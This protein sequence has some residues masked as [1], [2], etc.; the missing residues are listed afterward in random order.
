MYFLKRSVTLK[1][2]LVFALVAC[3]YAQDEELD[4]LL[5][6]LVS[7]NPPA[8]TKAPAQPESKTDEAPA[9][10]EKKADPQV[11][12]VPAAEEKKPAATVDTTIATTDEKPAEKKA[13]PAPEPAVAETK[14]E[15]KVEAPA[16]A[17]KK[18][19]STA[20]ELDSLLDEK[21]AEKKAEPAPV[22]AVVETKEEPKIEAPAVA[23]KKKEEVTADGILI[24]S[25]LDEKPAEKKAEPAPAPAVAETK[26][27]PKVEAPAVEK[28]EVAPKP[29]LTVNDKDRPVAEEKGKDDNEKKAEPAEDEKKEVA[30]KDG[31][32]APAAQESVAETPAKPENLSEEEVA[33][34]DIAEMERVRREGL[35]QHANITLA[36]AEAKLKEGDYD[37]VIEILTRIA[38]DKQLV[39]RISGGEARV[40]NLL[41][42]AYYRKSRML[43]Q[44]GKY[45][46]AQSAANAALSLKHPAAEQQLKR[47]E[48]ALNE[49][50]VADNKSTTPPR[51]AQEEYKSDRELIRQR[52]NRGEQYLM[53]GELDKAMEEAELV[54]SENPY[55]SD[56]MR[57]RRR[58][59]ERRRY[60]AD[61]HE[62]AATRK[63][64]IATV[65][66]T[67][68]PRRTYAIDSEA[69]RSKRGIGSQVTAVDA[70][71]AVSAEKLIE[72]KLND[73]KLPEVSFR[74]PATVIDAIDFFNQQSREYDDPELEIS[75]RGVNFVLKLN[76]AAQAPAAEPAEADPFAAA[77]T[78]TASASTS[79]AP[80]IPN[81]SARFISLGDALKLVCDVTGMKY[82]VK[83]NIVMVMPLNEPE[84]DFETRTYNV[85]SSMIEKMKPTENSVS[86]SSNGGNAFGGGGE[87]AQTDN[88][89]EKWK[90][91][92]GDM[93]VLW[94]ARSSIAYI[95]SVSKLRVTNT[96]ENLAVFEQVLQDLNVTPRQIEIEARFV[97]VS[98]KDLNS[99]GFEWALNSDINIKG[100]YLSA[101]GGAAGGNGGLGNITP[102]GGAL[103]GSSRRAMQLKA[104]SFANGMRFLSTKD[105]S[106]EYVNADLAAEDSF[107]SFNMRFGDVDLSMIL[108]MLSQRSD[109]D[110]L[111]APKVVTRDS[112][113]AEMKV[114]EEFIYP[115]GYDVTISQQGSSS[116]N[117]SYSSSS[118]GEPLAI[119]QPTGFITRDVG[120]ILKVTP[121]V[122]PDG[123]MINLTLAPEVCEFKQWL[124]YGT[125]YPRSV[126]SGEISPITGEQVYKTEWIE[127]P[128]NQP[129]F[130]T[131]KASAQLS[132]YNGATVVLGGMITEKRQT[133]DDKIP[134]LGDLPWIGFLFRSKAEVSDKRNLLIFVTARLVD[135]AGRAI[136]SGGDSMSGATS[137]GSVTP[138]PAPVQQKQ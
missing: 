105:A 36:D 49:P 40:N 119:V 133:I 53:S 101:E 129:L 4:A 93:G 138:P 15:P 97:E 26:A 74:P 67:W 75:K 13:E 88:E 113:E 14:E 132:I 44:K 42:E 89:T 120:V 86:G 56:A 72:K 55:N 5:S 114:V 109:T 117:S 27:E 80:V 23:E 107:A 58:V 71:N 20:S 112:V 121:Q 7:E 85:V 96:P 35:K 54:L 134:Y 106:G 84:T 22:P 135:P 64:M 123:Q 125:R 24:D 92:F 100:D 102:N 95:E 98:Q 82:I 99:M 77:N 46:E 29:D 38:N 10:V 122:T 11:A 124:E 111:S 63:N 81:I 118:T 128:M 16:V 69:V 12:P 116:G 48:T 136:I 50:Q 83:K 45:K 90:K 39:S 70:E 28:E 30:A 57:L 137:G 6:D 59:S 108:H 2:A 66:E 94:P 87:A 3:V 126:A 9:A 43:Y 76:S 115:E 131:R 60:L 68:S 47:C 65:A 79:G 37:S 18:E 61:T 127:V 103:Q 34:N 73:I 8:E 19:E 17:E 51:I 91:F 25:L 33:I 130:H 52:L 62:R 41:A 31:E 32:E 1:I 21:P 110:L 78:A 104:G